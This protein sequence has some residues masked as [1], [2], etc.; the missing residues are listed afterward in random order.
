MRISFSLLGENKQDH[1]FYVLK[2]WSCLFLDSIIFVGVQT[3]K[4]RRLPYPL[5][6]RRQETITWP[7]RK[8]PGRPISLKKA[9]GPSLSGASAE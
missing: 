2:A 3:Q 7:S 9:F 1:A 5:Y 4:T 8:G 6:L